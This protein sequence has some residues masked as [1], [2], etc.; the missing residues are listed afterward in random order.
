MGEGV[1]VQ[2]KLLEDVIVHEGVHVKLVGIVIEPGHHIGG[3]KPPL[4]P[5][6]IPLDVVHHFRCLVLQLG[7]DD[8]VGGILVDYRGIVIINAEFRLIG[9]LGVI[10]QD[11]GVFRLVQQEKIAGFGGTLLVVAEVD[12]VL[13][14][15]DGLHQHIDAHIFPVQN[16]LAEADLRGIA[17]DLCR[18]IH[19]H[20]VAQQGLVQEGAVKGPVVFRGHSQEGQVVGRFAARLLPQLQP[21]VVL[22]KVPGGVAP[23]VDQQ[24]ALH[25]GLVRRVMICFLTVDHGKRG[26]DLR[27]AILGSTVAQP[28][29]LLVHNGL[30]RHL[31]PAGVDDHQGQMGAQLAAVA[32]A[33]RVRLP[34]RQVLVDAVAGGVTAG[35]GGRKSG[36]QHQHQGQHPRHSIFHSKFPLSVFLTRRISR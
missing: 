3:V 2:Q 20:I 30:P 18:D 10:V 24:I 8:L 17:H 22:V 14:F 11:R 7:V 4:H 29:P 9:V 12:A 25:G 31:L 21:V 6:D 15:L 36:Q 16:E 5:A 35:G 33:A 26:P 1:V 19:P 23:D 13:V 28:V 32:V 34:G 27:A